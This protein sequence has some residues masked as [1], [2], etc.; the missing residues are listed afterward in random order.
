MQK[1]VGILVE[2]VSKPR[3]SDGVVWNN[4]W[5]KGILKEYLLQEYF[6]AK[7][8]QM[9]ERREYKYPAEAMLL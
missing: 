4:K 1:K 7:V 9:E 5:R 2:K 8:L 6:E 3:H